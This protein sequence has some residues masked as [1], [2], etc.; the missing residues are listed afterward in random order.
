M[1][2]NRAELKRSAKGMLAA[3]KPSPISVGLVYLAITVVFSLL[4][5]KL[6][7]MNLTENDLEQIMRHIQNGNLEYAMTYLSEYKPSTSSYI[8]DLA[9]QIVSLMVGTGFTIFALNTIRG[10]GACYGNL[11]DGF[12]IFFRVILLEILAGLFVVLWSLLLIVPGIIAAYRYRMAMYILIDHPEMSVMAC[13]RESKRLMK[14]H[15]WEL[16]VLDLSF[17]GWEILSNLTIIGWAVSIYTT[18][19]FALTYALYYETL[20][21]RA[22]LH[23]FTQPYSGDYR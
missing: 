19:Y 9:L 1:T 6:M 4:S 23:G 7:G 21:G 15:K 16:F 10:T 13:L 2:S 14:G 12:G 5:A 22:V 3:A 11:L 8:I 17:I 18:P 20:S